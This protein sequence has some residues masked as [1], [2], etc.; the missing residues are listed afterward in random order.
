MST[1]RNVTPNPSG[2]WDVTGAGS[3]RASSHHDTQADAR[4]RAAEIVA[5]QGG[6]EVSVHGTNGQ[7]RAK[8]TIPTGRDP[9]NIKG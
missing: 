2:G 5:N 6:G 8:D 9:R 7:I 1:N 3:G 4:T